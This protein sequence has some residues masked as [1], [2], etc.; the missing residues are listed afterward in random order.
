VCSV[1]CENKSNRKEVQEKSESD[2][3][4]KKE[5]ERIAEEITE[6]SKN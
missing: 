6:Q 4:R 5:R 2:R 1:E 3:K